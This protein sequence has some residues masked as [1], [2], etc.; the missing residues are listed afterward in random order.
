MY[1]HSLPRETIGEDIPR[2]GDSP[3]QAKI[4][5]MKGGEKVADLIRWNP[6]DELTR[7][8]EDFGRMLTPLLGWGSAPTAGAGWG[9]SV[10]VR[11]TDTH[12]EVSAEIPGVNPG[13]LDLTITDD[14]LTIRGEVKHASE[15]KEGG[16]RR[17]ERR[18]G[19]FHRTIPFP[20]SVKHDEAVA[21]YKNGI[22]EVRAPKAEPGKARAIRLKIGEDRPQLQ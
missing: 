17:V 14:S 15:S 16:F 21:D 18:Y 19:A 11:E 12:I 5:S 3:W 13:D 10:D 8:R 20:V 7:L 9:P 4:W 6:Y 22:L 1:G 2:T